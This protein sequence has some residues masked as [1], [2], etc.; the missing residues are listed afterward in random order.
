MTVYL[1]ELVKEIERLRKEMTEVALQKGMTSEE[2]L[3]ISQKLDGL[4][5]D[6]QHYKQTQKKEALPKK[7]S[8]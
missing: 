2:S 8:S 7:E 1:N 6:Y 4:L 3:Q 5:N